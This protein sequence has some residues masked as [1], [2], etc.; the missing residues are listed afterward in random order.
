MLTYGIPSYKLEKDIIDAEIDILRELGVEIKCGIEVGKNITIEDLRK[1][2]YKAFYVAI[3]CQGG[4][5][6]GVP[7]DTAIGTETAVE[8]LKRIAKDQNQK[9][10]GDVVVVG[11]GNVAIDSARTST[12]LGAKS[13]SMFVL[14]SRETMPA[15]KLEIFEAEEENVKINNGWG[16]KEIFV[17]KKNEVTA[18]TFKKCLSTVDENGKFNPKY[19]ED[20]TMTVDAD[21][22]IFAIG[23]TIDW[24]KLLDG[25][26]VKFWHGN[27]PVADSLTYQTDEPDIFVGG[28]VYSGPK[29]AIDAIEAGK[30]AAES[31]HRFVRPGAS[32]TIGRNRRDFVMLDKDNLEIESYDTAG[33]QE[34]GMTDKF[35]YKK[36]FRDAHNTLTE[37]QVKIETKRC[38]GCGA[39][40]VDENK[41]IGCGICTTKCEFDAI[42]LNRDHPEASTMIKSEDKFKAI[43]PYAIKRGCK[44]LFGKKTEAEKLSEKKHK[45]YVKEQKRKKKLAKKQAKAGEK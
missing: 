12:R 4:R 11:G 31:L 1:M 16:P 45:E 29:F 40:E 26:K 18:I 39:S 7:N 6:P 35:D 10:K 21:H 38:L 19:D 14:E 3:G 20:D 15:T 44:I 9:L 23:Q 17:N 42:H 32:L 8:F 25:T 30:N 2:G 37:E 43:L 5:L 24:G 41:C 22:I 28:D 13:V 34:A 27:Y 36:S 33:R